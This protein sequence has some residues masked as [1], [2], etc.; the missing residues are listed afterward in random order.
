MIA[1]LVSW[2][3]ATLLFMVSP[4]LLL[5]LLDLCNVD[6]DNE[7]TGE[8]IMLP[9]LCIFTFPLGLIGLCVRL[10]YYVEYRR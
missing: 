5:I 1:K 3:A 7:S 2:I 4:I 10:A 6:I 9:L 8:L